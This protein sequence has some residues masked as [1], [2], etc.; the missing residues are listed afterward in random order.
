[1]ALYL[2]DT[3]VVSEPVSPRSERRLVERLAR[4]RAVSSI[5]ATTVCELYWGV[6]RL[7]LGGRRAGLLEYLAE[8]FEQ[9]EGVLPYDQTAAEWHAAERARLEALG[10]T[11]P[12]ADGQIAAVAAV[13]DLTLVT[14]NPRDFER[15]E[16]VRVEAWTS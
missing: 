9:I 4:I 5:S 8:F 11:P 10:R 7:P 6:F 16:G 1:M 3:N 13:N 15:F 14:L 12:F 2:V